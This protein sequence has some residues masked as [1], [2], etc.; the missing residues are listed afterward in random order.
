MIA[1]GSARTP[2]LSRVRH[3][4]LRVRPCSLHG[5]RPRVCHRVLVQPRSDLGVAR[6]AAHDRYPQL[7]T[8]VGRKAPK[9]RD[10]PIGSQSAPRREN[11]HRRGEQR[12]REPRPD[13]QAVPPEAHES[14]GSRKTVAEVP[15]TGLSFRAVTALAIG[16]IGMRGEDATGGHSVSEPAGSG[17][18]SSEP[19]PNTT[20]TSFATQTAGRRQRRSSSAA[21]GLWV[22]GPRGSSGQAG[23]KAAWRRGP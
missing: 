2:R 15:L 10:Q 4:L 20:P 5:L 1:G 11:R 21:A 7:V 13:A 19:A 8:R 17:R 9:R 22:R 23:G 14:L 16:N 12:F 3:P 6:R 18:C